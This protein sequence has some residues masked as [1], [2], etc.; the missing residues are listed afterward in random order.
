LIQ[1]VY[2][3]SPIAMW[4]IFAFGAIVLDACAETVDKIVIVGDMAI[5]TIVATFYR[6]VAYYVIAVAI[7]L[8]GLVGPMHLLFSWPVLL[9]GLSY[10]GSACFYTYMLK[11]VELTGSSALGY[12]RPAIFLL[13][14]ITLLKAPFNG[15]Q[16]LGVLLLVLGG[17]LFVINPLTHKLKPEYTKYV[18]MIFLYETIS[19]AAEFYV[20]K[21]YATAINLNEI[22]YLLST[23]TVM[24][25]G[26]LALTLW[27][28]TWKS[29]VAT[30]MHKHYIAKVTLSK[31]FDVA[32]TLFLYH[33]LRLATVSQVNA[34]EAF[35]PLIL[36]VILYVVE[37]DFRFKARERFDRL[38][39][40]QKTLATF[41]LVI[42]IW[43]AG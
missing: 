6:N 16:I 17:I 32:Y 40:V 15:A 29:M 10:I 11:H 1:L 39:L 35:Y 26:L 21:H 5:N 34:M 20:F 31:S 25:I 19:Y 22:S 13:A 7:G 27:Q 23:N 3:N 4:Q 28:G 42:G 38:S 33:A 18:W 12:A 8:T 43:L 9:V 36:L 14:D 41:V 37:E 30:A 24:I 2:E